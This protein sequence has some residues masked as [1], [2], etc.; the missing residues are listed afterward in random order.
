MSA[1]RSTFRQLR[2]QQFHRHVRSVAAL[3]CRSI[4]L[5]V[6][7]RATPEVIGWAAAW[8]AVRFN[9]INDCHS[10]KL[11]LSRI[12]LVASTNIVGHCSL[13]FLVFVLLCFL[14][15]GVYNGDVR[16][17]GGRAYKS[18]VKTCKVRGGF[19]DSYVIWLTR[20]GIGWM[21]VKKQ[22]AK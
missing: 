13:W 20:E 3:G 12:T 6:R 8:K 15:G 21:I 4:L 22:R 17:K 14:F 18:N 19:T 7:T 11:F 16:W 10:G 5:H 1:C 2:G 9:S